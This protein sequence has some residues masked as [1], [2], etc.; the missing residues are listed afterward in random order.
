M[1]LVKKPKIT[2]VCGQSSPANLRFNNSTTMTEE[3]YY[4]NQKDL[5]SPHQNLSRLTILQLKS[6]ASEMFASR[7][8]TA[9]FVNVA[10][11]AHKQS[12]RSSHAMGTP[13]EMRQDTV[14]WKN[15]TIGEKK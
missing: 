4:D 15:I 12:V 8:A 9:R 6:Y 13:L 11:K 2:V 14:R 1:L 10:T 7:F 5:Q 3:V